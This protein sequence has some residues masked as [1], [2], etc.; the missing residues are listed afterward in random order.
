MVV[1]L[2]IAI[3]TTSH[4]VMMPVFGE[5]ATTVTIA[6]RRPYVVAMTIV[7]TVVLVVVVMIVV[8]RII[9]AVVMVP[10]VVVSPIVIRVVPAPTIMESIVI[11]IRRIVVRT[12]IIARPPPVVS[13]VN[14]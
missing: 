10:R 12:I 9:A 5:F 14:T 11:P 2:T 4:T 13:H 1:S 7:I 3:T 6:H 8:Y